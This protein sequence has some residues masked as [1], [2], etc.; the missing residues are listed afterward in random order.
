M[1]TRRRLN[2]LNETQEKSERTRERERNKGAGGDLLL[3]VS[4]REYVLS[5]ADEDLGGGRENSF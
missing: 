3:Y 2:W 4:M 1:C 5:S